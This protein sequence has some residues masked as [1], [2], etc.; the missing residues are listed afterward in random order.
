MRKKGWKGIGGKGCINPNCKF[1]HNITEEITE[2]IKNKVGSL[3]EKT[4]ICYSVW[5]DLCGSGPVCDGSCGF[6]HSLEDCV[7]SCG[8]SGLNPNVT[9]KKSLDQFLG[10]LADCI[11]K[12]VSDENEEDEQGYLPEDDDVNDDYEKFIKEIQ[13]ALEA[14][15]DF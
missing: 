14:P 3:L 11:G 1:N 6:A 5:A 2:E 13:Q 8:I 10:I 12:E 4:A 7:K 15:E 9:I